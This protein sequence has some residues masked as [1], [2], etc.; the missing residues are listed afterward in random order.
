M[1]TFK[2][3]SKSSTSVLTRYTLTKNNSAAGTD[4]IY[5]VPAGK[6]LY[7]IRLQCQVWQTN[8]AG[9]NDYARLEAYDGVTAAVVIG[10][11][12]L[13][14]NRDSEIDGVGNKCTVVKNIILGPGELL[15]FAYK[16]NGG[17]GTARCD[18]DFAGYLFV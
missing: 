17:G 12:G 14:L 8:G 15:R 11:T 6:N 2:Q 3:L 18:L 9:S 13:Q 4:T 5:T 16:S 10:E 1:T 7:I